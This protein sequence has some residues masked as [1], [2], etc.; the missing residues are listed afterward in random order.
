MT[1]GG[2]IN[3]RYSFAKSIYDNNISTFLDE[4]NNN[5]EN[6]MKNQI[7][8]RFYI[9]NIQQRKKKYKFWK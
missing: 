8:S 6:I 5:L 1:K 2:F 7:H 9:M 3:T 4:N